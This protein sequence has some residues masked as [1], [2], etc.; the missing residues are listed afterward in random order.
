MKNPYINA[1][2]AGAYIVFIVFV[3]TRFTDKAGPDNSM[4]F[5]LIPMTMLSLFVLSAAIMSFLF[6]YRPL[7]MY[8]DGKKQEA[9]V[10]FGKTVGTFAVCA[11]VFL[12]LLLNTLK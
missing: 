5:F 3:M 4:S 2:L 12:G 6:V 7:T 1:I 11:L 8:L 10:F 9:V